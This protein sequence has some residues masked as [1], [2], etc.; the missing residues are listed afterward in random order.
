MK[1][2]RLKMINFKKFRNEEIEFQDGLTGIIGN[3]GAGKSTIVEAILWS[4]Y[5]NRAL[6]IKKDFLKNNNANISDSMSV[7]LVLG[8]GN[9]V[10]SIY[11]GIRASGQVEAYLEINNKR[12][13]RGV[14]DV[15]DYL[16]ERLHTSAQDFKKTFYARQKDLDNLLKEGGADKKEYLLKLLS[17]SDIKPKSNELI[18][19]NIKENEGKK[20]WLDGAL[21]EIGDVGPRLDETVI[22]ISKAKAEL[23]ELEKKERELG[24]AVQKSEM[25]NEIHSRKEQSHKH[26]AEEIFKLESSLSRKK[27]E[28]KS[29][30]CKLAEIDD[31][32][33]HLDELRP[34]LERYS[35]VKSRLEALEPIKRNYEACLK[36]KE[37]TN[38]QIEGIERLL[39]ESLERLSA[40]Q[41]DETLLE[42][43][44]PIEEEYN[45]LNSEI[46]E[47]E[48]HRDNHNQILSKL[49]EEKI[50]FTSIES[51]ISKLEKNLDEL[52]RSQERLSKIKPLKSDYDNLQKELLA[53]KI[54]KEAIDKKDALRARRDTL[55]GQIGILSTEE[56]A[57][58][59]ELSKL[60]DLTGKDAKLM[61]QEKDLQVQGDE[62]NCRLIDL[63][64]LNRV[65]QSK[66]SE[67]NA[68]L[69]RVVQLGAEGNCPTCERPL[70]EQHAVLRSKY[71]R[72]LSE[73][74]RQSEEIDI[75]I[76]SL[77]EKIN[78]NSRSKADLKKS[79]YSLHR[80]KIVYA[81]I[82][83]RLNATLDRKI[84]VQAE[85]EG[86]NKDLDELGEVEFDPVHFEDIT[87]IILDVEPQ[88]ADYESLTIRIEALPIVESELKEL[89][90]QQRASIQESQDLRERL[91]GL[92]YEEP[93][94][95]SLKKRKSELERDH[96]RA[97]SLLQKI[98]DIPGLSEKI[99]SQQ[100][101]HD[102]FCRKRLD[103]DQSINNLGF[104]LSEYEALFNEKIDLS[105]SQDE[106]QEIMMKLAAETE[107]RGKRDET[108]QAISDLEKDIAEAKGEIGSI[109][110][111]GDVHQ[112]FR[113]ALTECKKNLEYFR[114]Q[115]S[116]KR[117]DLGVLN[118]DLER[119][120]G[121]ERKRREYEQER[122]E[123]I[124]NLD[125][126]DIVRKLLDGFL[127]QLL[128]RIRKNIEDSAGEILQEISGKY[129]HIR[130]DDE[131]NICVEDGGQF[132]PISRYSG[133][134]ID[135]IAVSVRIAISEYLMRQERG[136]SGGYS[137][138]ILD[139]IFGSQDL[140]HRD[141]MIDTLR[142][143]DT[144][145]PQ[146]I[147][148]SHIGDVQGQFDNIINVIENEFGDSMVE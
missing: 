29:E 140:M 78:T 64:G 112:K 139:E 84:D 38:K 91:A 62:L 98:R 44:K 95:I 40:L 43:L 121:D 148:I 49:K 59:Q 5:G 134:E 73:A 124:K 87:N 3:N 66:K 146:V 19:A 24:V 63:N 111:D 56:N 103:L 68:S 20:N 119:L 100:L 90:V 74:E 144:R 125:M 30:D 142:R 70:G 77:A 82:E 135:M 55:V 61:E 94:Y 83:A 109:G 69:A 118:S 110:Y 39:K 136:G 12:I 60:S 34:K 42:K 137:F 104:N 25:D 97:I 123:S 18:K 33:K 114:P 72:E 32:K 105:R 88:I 128:I 35:Q 65:Y 75:E 106:A 86:I 27:N 1:L 53:L 11:R 99:S 133:G 122:S 36:R 47:M 131:F 46:P 7:K 147:V 9:Q 45:K 52:K 8:T 130:I 48:I 21:K 4:L 81:G 76:Q 80:D 85:L 17:L 102:E 41:K 92:G 54:R 138:L 101:E 6:S 116:E 14:K 2:I 120:K 108:A 50:N 113:V 127:D 115:L 58:L 15:D 96:E 129:D 71:M 22:N 57:A 132:Y 126:L 26:L 141:N 23:D 28:L 67:A 145:F 143:L 10:W 93:K 117:V 51:R 89:R 31:R 79:F 16:T 37:I 107:I 13:A